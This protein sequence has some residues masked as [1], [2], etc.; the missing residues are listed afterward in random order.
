ILGNARAL[1]PDYAREMVQ[2]RLLGIQEQQ[3]QTQQQQVQ[4]A[5]ARQQQQVGE[6]ASYR[7]EIQNLGS[8]P[9]ASQVASL[10]MRYPQ[11]SEDIK[12]G[13]DAQ[14]AARRNTDFRQIAEVNSAARAGNWDVAARLLRQRVEADQQAG[15]EP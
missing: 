7:T 8:N 6:L 2:Q 9:T 14:D 11:F 5:I 12:R 4:A 15:E 1:V 10:I 3:A 13:W